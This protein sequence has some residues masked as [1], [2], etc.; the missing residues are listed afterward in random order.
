MRFTFLV[1]DAAALQASQTTVLLIAD[2]IQ[3]GHEVFVTG[4]RDLSISEKATPYAYVQK[5]KA[6]QYSSRKEL[7]RVLAKTPPKRV[8]LGDTDILM[9]RTNP[10]RDQEIAWA[11]QL[12][13]Q[14]AQMCHEEGVLVLNYPLGLQKASSKFYLLGFPEIV[15]PRTIVSQ[16][17]E[18]I[19]SFIRKL[20]GPAVLK[21]LLGTRGS[22]VFFVSSIEDK[23]LNQII[24]V[25]LRQSALM[26]QAFVPGAEAGDTRVVVMN[27]DV[28]EINGKPA[29]INRVPKKDELRSNIHAGGSAQ[30]GIVTNA[31]LKTIKTMK[32]YLMNDGL[33]LVGLDF[34]GS[35]VIEVNAYSTGGLRDAER[36]HEVPF[37]ARVIEE[38]VAMRSKMD[39]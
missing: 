32:P 2:A 28:L 5:P 19:K 22:D 20:D 12:A 9:I 29:A 23:N 33:S 11:H 13:L 7:V 35:K 1:N 17:P 4:V 10:A 38:T 24:E 31:M 15:R 37:S 8:K 6:S 16:H 18:A 34:I 39:N 25:I 14:F 26:A 36:F 3:A 21:P 30:P 27:G